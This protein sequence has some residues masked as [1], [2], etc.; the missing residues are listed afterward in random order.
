MI[1]CEN[2]SILLVPKGELT[3]KSK[4]EQVFYPMPYKFYLKERKDVKLEKACFL[5]T[6]FSYFYT[7]ISTC[8][9]AKYDW[10]YSTFHAVLYIAGHFIMSSMSLSTTFLS[11]TPL[12]EVDHCRPKNYFYRFFLYS[13]ARDKIRLIGCRISASQGIA[14]AKHTLCS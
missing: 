6:Y 10:L 13:H 4:P 1:N 14:R 3:Y 11:P 12:K 5:K 9:N 2:F 8:S 7:N